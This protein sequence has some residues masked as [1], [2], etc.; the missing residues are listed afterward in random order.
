[1][2]ITVPEQ[3]FLQR[4]KNIDFTGWNEAEVREG[5]IIDLLHTLGYRKGTT[6]DLELEKSL[7]L[8]EPYHR[9]GRKKVDI[10]YAPSVRKRFFWIIEAKPGKAKE[11]KMGDLLQ[12]HLYAVHPEVQAR[13]VVLINGWQIR[14]Y[15][16]LTLTSW[17]DP[18]LVVNQTDAEDKFRELREMIGAPSM[19]AY[20]RKRLLD[21]VHTTLESEVDV[22]AFDGLATQLRTLA[23]EG[24]RVVE[25]NARKLWVSAMRKY[26]EDE[27]AELKTD[28]TAVLFVKMDLPEDGRPLPAREFVRRV[29]AADPGEQARL[30]DLLAMKYR[31]RPHNIFRVLA[32]HALVDLCEAGIS[33][34]RSSYVTSIPTSIDELALANVGYWSF[35]DLANALCHLDNVA[36]R[37]AMKMC[38]R[39]RPLFEQILEAWEASM[40]TEERVKHRPALDGLVIK[41]AGHLQE[42]IW[43]WYCSGNSSA[44]V[45]DG[46]WNLHAVEAELDKMP[47]LPA[48]GSSLDFYGFA[49]WG[50]SHDQLLVGTWDVLSRAKAGV[51]TTAGV[52]PRVLDFAGKSHEEVRAQI[53]QERRAPSG[54]VRTKTTGD[55]TAA[56]AKVLAVRLASTVGQQV[57]RTS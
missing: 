55:V 57:Q 5:F 4:W 27:E 2:A 3:L 14:V 13:L 31:A 35:N 28:T 24:R 43:R 20:Q 38:L 16:A 11:M 36:M 34:P 33:V 19:L 12:V 1:M 48:A 32:L 45:W 39:A 49:F 47:P 29:T 21:I 9:I 22:G 56:L 18:L 7:K 54:W 44:A 8:A 30:V 50:L 41:S 10:D 53:P 23:S 52:D 42:I 17:D 46:I 6:Y 51:L 15:D 26:F 25:E 40:T 37:I